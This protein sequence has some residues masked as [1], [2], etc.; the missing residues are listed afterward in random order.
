MAKPAG[1][2]SGRPGRRLLAPAILTVLLAPALAWPEPIHGQTQMELIAFRYEPVDGCPAVVDRHTRL[3]WQRCS[4]G[5]VW[6]GG[7]CV[8]RPAKLDWSAASVR[9]NENCGFDDWHLPVVTELEGLVAEGTIP[10]IDPAVFPNTPAGSFWTA[11]VSEGGGQRA[12]FVNFGRG[13]A[14]HMFKDARF[15]VRLVR[16]V[17]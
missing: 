11:S 14:Q 15:H 9:Q 17:R 6:E 13:H 1:L 8:G 10:A 7:T 4:L 5:Q 12:W 3:M 2:V 16:E